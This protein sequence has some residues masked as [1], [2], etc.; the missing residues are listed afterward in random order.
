MIR[1]M[2]KEDDVEVMIIRI[3]FKEDYYDK[4]IKEWEVPGSR[5]P[6]FL[7]SVIA[8][9]ENN[10]AMPINTIKNPILEG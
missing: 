10:S 4:N 6:L 1:I 2:F 9:P 7:P 8:M 5:S 3:I